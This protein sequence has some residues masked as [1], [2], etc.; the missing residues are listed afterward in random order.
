[1]YLTPGSVLAMLQHFTSQ[2]LFPHMYA[3]EAYPED[4]LTASQRSSEGYG[5]WHS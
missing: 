4:T 1:M 2:D 3:P 5:Y